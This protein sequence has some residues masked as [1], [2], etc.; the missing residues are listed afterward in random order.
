MNI[1][2]IDGMGG[3]IGSQ[4]ISLLRQDLPS[5][6]KIYALGTNSAA[7]SNMMKEKANKG[8]TGESAITFVVNKVDVIVGSL[9]IIIPNSMLGEITPGIATAIASCNAKKILI[10]II[11]NEDITL[12]GIEKKPLFLAIKDAIEKIKELL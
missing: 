9:G 11:D 8:A 6:V 4:I 1:A 2:V 12:L 7:T 3:G 5:D 10:P